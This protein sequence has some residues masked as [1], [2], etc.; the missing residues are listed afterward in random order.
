MKTDTLTNK[1]LREFRD[2]FAQIKG[3]YPKK[4]LNGI[5]S[6]GLEAGESFLTQAISQ[7]REEEHKLCKKVYVGTVDWAEWAI[8]DE[9]AEIDFE[10]EYEDLL[11]S[12]AKKE[13]E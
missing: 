8:S 3:Y 6:G 10:Q 1:I 13:G 2:K 11:D 9:D 12:L 4:V 5:F 7:V